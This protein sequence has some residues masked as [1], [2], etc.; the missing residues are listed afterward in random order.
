MDGQWK[1]WMEW[2]ECSLSCGGGIQTRSRDC[3]GPF[4]GGANCTGSNEDSQECNTH[5]CPGQT[6][7]RTYFISLSDDGIDD[8][9][10]V[11]VFY[12]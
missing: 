8:Y 7:Q 1:D 5:P 3:E 6:R 10:N 2:R 11:L 9:I 4:Y 12:I